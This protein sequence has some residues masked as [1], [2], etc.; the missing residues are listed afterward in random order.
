[1]GKFQT[2]CR[3]AIVILI[4][5]G[6]SA[7]ATVYDSDGS[8]TN[9]QYIHDMLARDGDTITVPAGTFGWTGTL[10]LTKAIILKGQTI[11]NDDGT[12]VDNTIIQDAKPDNGASIR[13]WGNGGQRVTGC[14]F[15]GAHAG[16][17]DQAFIDVRG[18]TPTRIDHCVFDHLND[19]P[20]IGWNDYNYGVIDH[21]TKR[22]PVGTDGIAHIYMGLISNDHGDLHFTQ[23]PGFG[24]PNFLFIEDNL[25][26][27]GM[28]LSLGSKVV[29]RYNTFQQANM[30]NHGTGMSWHDGRGSRAIEIYNNTWNLQQSYHTLTSTNAGPVIIHDNVIR[31]Y[32]GDGPVAGLSIQYY[33][34]FTDFGSPFYMADGNNAWDQNDPQL[35]TLLRGLDQPG[36]G[37]QVGTMDRANP[38]WM[39]QADE[40]CYEWNNTNDHGTAI[41][42]V[43]GGNNTTILLSRD[44]FNDTP[45]P[46]YTPYQYPHPLV[47]G[48]NPSPTPTATATAT[49]TPAP[50]PTPTVTPTPTG[51]TLV[52]HG[53][54]VHRILVIDLNWSGANSANVDIFRDGALIA[55]V[56]N[57]GAYTDSTGNTG[58]HA[59]YTYEVCEA[60]TGNCSNQ[61][62]ITF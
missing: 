40:P 21:N 2:L 49:S 34:Q 47:G 43:I 29:V 5:N 7:L 45:M 41:H 31:R 26:A 48:G 55:T 59:S 61:V 14:T 12:S 6:F 4:G 42:Y 20:A 53:N 27:G 10:R 11:R 13:L 9:L 39:Q 36:L 25:L 38:R 23:P 54:R 28:D 46:G 58:R 15:V 50:T 16:A 35:H 17:H 57:T 22:N 19:G 24:G 8:P 37:R 44:Y 56:P 52:A 30:A 18:T 51:I 33:R 32:P 62:T 1:M 3:S 60:S